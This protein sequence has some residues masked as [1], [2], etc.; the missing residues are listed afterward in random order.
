MKHALFKSSA[1]ARLELE[2]RSFGGSFSRK[3][4]TLI[5]LL[6]VIAI[7]AILAALL[8]PALA[9]AKLR[10]WQISCA[11]NLKQLAEASVMYQGDYGQIGYNSV[12]GVWLM[13]LADMTGHRDSSL[14]LCPAAAD[15]VGAGDPVAPPAPNAGR[16]GTAAKCWSWFPP[17]VPPP[18]TNMGSYTINGWLYEL[19]ATVKSMQDDIPPGQYL[20]EGSIKRTSTTPMFMDGIWPDTWP[21]QGDPLANGGSANLLTG[22]PSVTFGRVM[23]SRHGSRRPSA[24]P[25]AWPI[26]KHPFPGLL[27]IVVADGHVEQTHPDNLPSYTWNG[28]WK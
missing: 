8:L 1:G 11:S 17:T 10:A 28:I 13:T 24:A 27:N 7:I 9:A 5:E 6:V 22:D 2:S 19:N 18:A 26:T 4:F 15:P 14:R 23:I 3:G 12:G 21:K 25:T 16:Q 20:K